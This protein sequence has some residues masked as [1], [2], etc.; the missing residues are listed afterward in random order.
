MVYNPSDAIWK[1]F[2]I[3]LVTCLYMLEQ[4]VVLCTF[5]DLLFL[6]CGLIEICTYNDNK[7]QAHLQNEYQF[8]SWC[9]LTRWCSFLSLYMK[10]KECPRNWHMLLSRNIW[11][12]CE[13]FSLLSFSSICSSLY[14]RASISSYNTFL[15]HIVLSHGFRVDLACTLKENTPG[16]T[17]HCRADTLT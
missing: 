1:S 14:A 6:K 16:L 5:E 17:D 2:W 8:A 10:T 4:I 9:P 13:Q 15:C 7:T 12:S 3:K 11:G